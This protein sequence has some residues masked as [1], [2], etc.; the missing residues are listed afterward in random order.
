MSPIESEEGKRDIRGII[1]KIG[2]TGSR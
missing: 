1:E 2:G